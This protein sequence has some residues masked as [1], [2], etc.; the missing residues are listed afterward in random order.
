MGRYRK[1]LVAFDA[2]P[3]SE[4]ALR[5]ALAFAEKEDSWVKVL[6]VVPSYE[7]ELELVGVRNM[8]AALRGPVEGLIK[9]AREIAGP[10]SANLI[11]NVEQGEAYEKIVDIADA[12]NCD[13]IVMGRRGLRHLE[14]MLIGSVTERVIGHTS[15]DVLVVPRDATVEI[16]KIVVATDGSR[17]GDAAVERALYF[18]DQYGASLTAVTVVDMFPEHYAEAAKVIDSLEKKAADVLDAVAREA[19]AAKVELRTELLKGD[20]AD[21][22]TRF[23]KE[24]GAGI[25]FVGSHGRSGLKKMLMGSVAE[26]IVGLASSPVFVAKPE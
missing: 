2:S 12:E 6:A 3:S 16:D 13:L 18:A 17:Y 26:K 5:Q 9:S 20:P 23:A 24:A 10:D 8:E 15:R 4:N 25:V 1:I 21:E 11:T 7:G 19:A 14:R 22:V